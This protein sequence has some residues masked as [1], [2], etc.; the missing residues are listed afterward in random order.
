M[1]I[2]LKSLL[3]MSALGASTSPWA[4][5]EM[6]TERS[7]GVPQAPE[8]LRSEGLDDQSVEDLLADEPPAAGL[9][10]SIAGMPAGNRLSSPRPSA[11]IRRSG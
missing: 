2:L 11:A 8:H 9:Y 10:F 7:T 1:N 5:V 4:D 3:V 6:L